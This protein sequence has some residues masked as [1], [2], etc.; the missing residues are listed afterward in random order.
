MSET[1]TRSFPDNS[2][3]VVNDQT[4]HVDIYSIANYEGATK[5]LDSD[6][7][8]FSLN[9]SDLVWYV[10]AYSE[11][12]KIGE[13]ISKS[14]THIRIKSTV[15]GV[16]ETTRNVPRHRVYKFDA[17]YLTSLVQQ[18][19]GFMLPT[20][21]ETGPVTD[22]AGNILSVGDPVI[23]SNRRATSFLLGI[24]SRIDSSAK[25]FIKSYTGS[26]TKHDPVKELSPFNLSPEER[27]IYAAEIPLNSTEIH[28]LDNN[29]RS[30]NVLKITTVAD[31]DI[32]DFYGVPELLTLARL[33]K[34][35]LPDDFKSSETC[36]FHHEYTYNKLKDSN[37]YGFNGFDITVVTN[38]VERMVRVNAP[39]T[40]AP[41]RPQTV[42]YI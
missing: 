3:K 15:A 17:Y 32:Q 21:T 22:V 36:L 42:V 35:L 33:G 27:A 26:Y 9:A 37:P 2:T 7:L 31:R 16:K 20:I 23:F 14:K 6:M 18:A 34:V 4:G 5:A 41:P 13:V 40:P 30:T 10:D 19:D 11:P 8:G 39:F 1:R 25:I 38:G 24:I 12:L 28:H 29:T